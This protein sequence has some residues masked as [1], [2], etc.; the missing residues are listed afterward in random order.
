VVHATFRRP[1]PTSIGKWLI[2]IELG[3]SFDGLGI[4]SPCLDLSNF[5]PQNPPFLPF[6]AI[7]LEFASACNE[8]G[9]FVWVCNTGS[10]SSRVNRKLLR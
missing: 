8:I 3:Q 10:A 9:P 5:L 2:I 6:S 4:G 1:H 7:P